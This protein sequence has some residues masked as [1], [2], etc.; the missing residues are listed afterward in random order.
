MTSGHTSSGGLMKA[1]PV[2][3]TKRMTGR[4]VG[5]VT[6]AAGLALGAAFFGASGAQASS[7]REAPLTAGDPKIDNTDVYAFVSPDKTDT[8]TLLANWIPF[9]EPNG[10]PN[11][12]PWQ[13]G[14]H[15]DLNIDNDG[16]A[17]ADIVY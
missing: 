10:G 8:V 15:Y 14:A 2:H 9:E 5:A 4:R 1:R 11:F 12:Y 3:H 7:H 6:T 13:D 17:K 16:D